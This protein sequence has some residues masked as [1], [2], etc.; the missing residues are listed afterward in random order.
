MVNEEL[1]SF[2]FLL[3]ES[4]GSVKMVMS[5]KKNYNFYTS[6]D[7]KYTCII[8]RYNLRVRNFLTKGLGTRTYFTLQR[9]RKSETI[10]LLSTCAE[11]LA[12]FL[13]KNQ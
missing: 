6:K 11:L 12:L 8:I 10:M 1:T 3:V 4:H 13:K 5:W 2:A 7:M 9:E